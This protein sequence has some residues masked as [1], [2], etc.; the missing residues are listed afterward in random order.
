MEVVGTVISVL[1][2]KQ[3]TSKAGKEWKTQDFI[4]ETHD[5][6]P[7]KVCINVFGADKIDK[8]GIA[9]GQS[10]KVGFNLESREFNGNWFTTIGAWKIDHEAGGQ[11]SRNEEATV[12]EHEKLDTSSSS[13]D[14]D[15]P[16]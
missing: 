3:G 9:E 14:G 10:V 5:Q 11:P 7:R 8:F 4:I 16:F 15:L 1:P 12:E 6:Y 2:A 13:D